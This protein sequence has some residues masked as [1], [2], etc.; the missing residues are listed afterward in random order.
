[1]RQKPRRNHQEVAR[2]TRPRQ[3]EQ[4]QLGGERVARGQ[5]RR[6]TRQRDRPSAAPWAVIGLLVGA[7]YFGNYCEA[8]QEVAAQAANLRLHAEKIAIRAE[9]VLQLGES[10]EGDLD[11]APDP[12]ERS[13]EHPRGGTSPLRELAV[14]ARAQGD[15]TV[16]TGG[17]GRIVWTQRKRH[18]RRGAG[19]SELSECRRPAK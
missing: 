9:D 19:A 8:L 1:M 5:R 6:S 11:R 14:V 15:R 18:R 17:H 3:N 2:R 16:R 13:P 4:R 12:A 10:R 7:L